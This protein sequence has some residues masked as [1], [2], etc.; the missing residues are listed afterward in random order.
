MK[1]N[2]LAIATKKNNYDVILR[3]NFVRKINKSDG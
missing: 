1:P 3:G 2:Y